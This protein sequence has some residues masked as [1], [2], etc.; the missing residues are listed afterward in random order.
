MNL[1]DPQD[2]YKTFLEFKYPEIKDLLKQFLT[3][4]SASLVFSVT[5]SEKIISFQEASSLQKGFVYGAWVALIVAL[6][7]CG[8][9]LYLNYLTAERAIDVIATGNGATNFARL[10]SRAY[11]FQDLAGL[12]FGAGF[13]LLVLSAILKT[14]QPVE[15]P[16]TPLA[17]IPTSVTS[18]SETAKKVEP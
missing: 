11:L 18:P 9:G 3:L 12:L 10:E 8:F 6:G 2:V 16:S 5:F 15:K 14:T 1:T 4:I 17:P 13:V 7:A